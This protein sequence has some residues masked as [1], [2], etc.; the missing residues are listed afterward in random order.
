MKISNK[1]GFKMTNSLYFFYEFRSCI[2]SK[3][4][5]IQENITNRDCI[6]KFPKE[7]IEFPKLLLLIKLF[8]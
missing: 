8:L 6:Q 3:K 1:T 4:L 5:R 2:H 7:K